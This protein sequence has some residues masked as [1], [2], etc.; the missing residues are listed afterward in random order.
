MTRLRDLNTRM[1]NRHFLL[2]MSEAHTSFYSVSTVVISWVVKLSVRDA[3]HYLPSSLF[4]FV[5]LR[6]NAGHDPLIL[7]FF[8]DHTQRRT[9]V[10]R[11]PLDE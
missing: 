9:T 11:T 2:S 7:E 4:F 6:P 5:A 3:N 10:G 1:G 8:L